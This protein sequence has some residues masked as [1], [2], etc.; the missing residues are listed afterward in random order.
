ME[1][2]TAAAE[3]FGGD[4]HQGSTGQAG[5]VTRPAF[6]RWIDTFVSEKGLNTEHVFTVQTDDFWGTHLIPLAVVIE[7]AKSAPLAEQAQVKKAFVMI[8][9]KNGDVMHFFEYLAK[10]LAQT[11]AVG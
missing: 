1:T 10:G 11:Y 4:V 2:R 8:D 3:L 6:A 5:R 7:A 9:F